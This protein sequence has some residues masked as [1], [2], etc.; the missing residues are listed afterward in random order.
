[1]LDEK[2]KKF[3]ELIKF[4][5]TYKFVN[6]DGERVKVNNLSHRE[7]FY[8][9]LFIVSNQ[10]LKDYIFIDKDVYNRHQGPWN[11]VHIEEEYSATHTYWVHRIRETE[12]G[13]KI[14]LEV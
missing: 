7:Y 8:G 4:V 14:L 2:T 10:S 9:I 6:A 3:K 12:I 11:N 1:M 5:K 13:E